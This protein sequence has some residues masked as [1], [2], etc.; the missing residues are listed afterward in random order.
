MLGLKTKTGLRQLTSYRDCL[1]YG[2]VATEPGSMMPWVAQIRVNV[3]ISHL[4]HGACVCCCNKTPFPKSTYER[5][6]LLSL[7]FKVIVHYFGAVKG[8]TRSTTSNIKRK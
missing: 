5:K 7:Q 3:E 4:S 8:K 2:M 6:G 1:D